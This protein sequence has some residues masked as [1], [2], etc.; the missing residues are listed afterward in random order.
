MDNPGH[1]GDGKS[2]SHE[3][4]RESTVGYA[5]IPNNHPESDKVGKEPRG[6]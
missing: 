1:D 6:P 3:I 4:D 5:I 2:N